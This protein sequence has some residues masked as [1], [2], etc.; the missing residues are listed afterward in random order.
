MTNSN[1]KCN[2]SQSLPFQQLDSDEY[3]EMIQNNQENGYNIFEISHKVRNL[4][5]NR[6][7][8]NYEIQN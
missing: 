2:D 3:N 5:F 8:L 6:L 7:I 1:N 4:V